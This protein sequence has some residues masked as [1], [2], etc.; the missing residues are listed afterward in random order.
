M[1]PFNFFLKG[2][3]PRKGNRLLGCLLGTL[4]IPAALI[5]SCTLPETG[6]FSE[7]RSL[8]D[9]SR[10]G[11]YRTI[12]VFVENLQGSEQRQAEERVVAELRAAGIT[13]ERG[14]AVYQKRTKALSE[15]EKATLI[16][17]TFEAVL[18]VSVV[19]AGESEK[20]VDADHNSREINFYHHSSGLNGFLKSDGRTTFEITDAIRRKYILKPDGTVY[21]PV[22]AIKT[23]SDLQDTKTTVRVWTAETVVSEGLSGTTRDA[24]FQSVSKQIV[25]RLRSDKA[26]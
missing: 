15:A 26:I 19:E 5:A 2:T 1:A 7:T 3:T 23:N 25:D 4:I 16:Q 13:A 20:P 21:E 12:A 9:D 11:K 10:E 14:E 22:L 8:V 24:L 6:R 18:Y 17:K